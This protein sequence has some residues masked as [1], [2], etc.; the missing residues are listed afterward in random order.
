MHVT[1]KNSC[2]GTKGLLTNQD[3]A[4]YLTSLKPGDYRGQPNSQ[5]IF[6]DLL[7]ACH[8]ATNGTGLDAFMDWISQ[9]ARLYDVRDA[10]T[11]AW[12]D[13]LNHED[14]TIQTLAAELRLH[15]DYR[16]EEK[17]ALYKPARVKTAMRDLLRNVK[18]PIDAERAINKLAALEGLHPFQVNHFISDLAK[19]VGMKV[20]TLRDSYD[21]A[22]KAHVS[23]GI[24]WP[25]YSMTTRGHI[26]LLPTYPNF[27]H[28][29]RRYHIDIRTNTMTERVDIDFPA[30]HNRSEFVASE[31]PDAY[32]EIR[33]RAATHNFKFM[34]KDLIAFVRR[35]AQEPG[36]T[37]HPIGDWLSQD[38]W[39][40]LDRFNP[41]VDRFQFRHID[42]EQVAQFL[43]TFCFQALDAI[44]EPQGIG[45]QKILVLFGPPVGNKTAW[46]QSLVPDDKSDL[47]VKTGK[48]LPMD[49][50]KLKRAYRS[51]VM[52]RWLCEFI[53]IGRPELYEIGRIRAFLQS[54][55]DLVYTLKM[56]AIRH[57]YR[58]TAFMFAIS[59]KNDMSTFPDDDMLMVIPVKQIELDP[60]FDP[61]QFWLQ[62]KYEY[63]QQSK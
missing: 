9:D 28:L 51:D 15:G 44:Y 3:L 31:P 24:T 16:L 4:E 17:L 53:D 10:I 50:D 43:K 33:Q 8:H 26:K 7:T 6:L 63:D 37:Y 39:D 45:P 55:L 54:K 60:H 42:R 25:N 38:T 13:V 18:T 20:A 32:A 29:C 14:N 61:L 19:R 21:L 22:R 23:Q 40:G 49:M 46:L 52:D 48:P 34:D 5:E 30:A 12:N 47:W 27:L 11:Q 36:Q 1:T 2:R 56:K 58:R 62:L 57:R 35:R 41:M 59:S